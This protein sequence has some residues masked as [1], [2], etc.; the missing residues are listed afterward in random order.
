M[1]PVE[2]NSLLRGTCSVF[3]PLNPPFVWDSSHTGTALQ[4]ALEGRFQQQ[5]GKG[6]D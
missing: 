2:G 3:R 6:G 4:M 1:P 5:N